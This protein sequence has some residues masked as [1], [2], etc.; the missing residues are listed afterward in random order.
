MLVQYK[1]L[2][3]PLAETEHEQLIAVESP[4][5]GPPVKQP[6]QTVQ[7]HIGKT[8]QVVRLDSLERSL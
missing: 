7:R 4:R 5:I 8:P 1:M 2:G 3:S 6:L